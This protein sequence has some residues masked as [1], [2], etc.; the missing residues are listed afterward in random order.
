MK[1]YPAFLIYYRLP[2]KNE[3]R[4]YFDDEEEF[5]QRHKDLCYK[6]IKHGSVNCDS[7]SA[8]NSKLKCPIEVYGVL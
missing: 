2:C 3:I 6:K 7:F 1:S 8:L 5:K 4:E